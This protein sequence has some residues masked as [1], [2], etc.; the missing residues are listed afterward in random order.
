MECKM[1]NPQPVRLLPHLQQ[2]S[3]YTFLI[4]THFFMHN[5]CIFRI[6]LIIFHFFLA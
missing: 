5:N 6:F 4:Y 1:R 3:N 2:S